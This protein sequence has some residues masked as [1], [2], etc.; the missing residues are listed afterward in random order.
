MEELGFGA[1]KLRVYRL[2]GITEL[3]VWGLPQ[4]QWTTPKAYPLCRL[5][6]QE[7]M[8]RVLRKPATGVGVDEV[9]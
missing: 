6:L 4:F 5:C 1:L 3:K 9:G 7:N 8:H 2:S